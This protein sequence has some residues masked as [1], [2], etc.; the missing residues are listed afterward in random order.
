[1]CNFLSAIVMWGGSVETLEIDCRP[2]L[3]DSHGDLKA[4][5]QIHDTECQRLHGRA[6]VGVEY[7]PPAAPVAEWGD[8]D[9]WTLRLDD[10]ESEPEWWADAVPEITQRMRARVES[11]LIRDARDTVLGGCWI[12]LPGGRIARL[13]RGR[14][15]GVATDANLSGAYLSGADLSRADR[16]VRDAPIPGWT[17]TDAGTLEREVS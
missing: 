3:T 1:M 7:T 9:R 10:T 5:R 14:L 13:V 12:V 16:W 2:E 17:L 4:A 6:W 8:L 15:A 11:M